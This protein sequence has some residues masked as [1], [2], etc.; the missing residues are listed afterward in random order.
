[1]VTATSIKLTWLAIPEHKEFRG[2]S[3][4]VETDPTG[5]RTKRSFVQGNAGCVP[6]TAA[7]TQGHAAIVAD[8]CFQQLLRQELLKGREY[9]VEQQT[10]GGL[11][12]ATTGTSYEVG[13]VD[14]T[15]A[16]LSGLWRAFSYTS[17][18][19]ETAWEGGSTPSTKRTEYFYN[20]GCSWGGSLEAYGRLNCVKEFERG[21]PFRGM[22]WRVISEGPV[23]QPNRR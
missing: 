16:P 10:S 9:A 21:Y 19:D 8:S 20:F 13:P 22:D 6:G 1:M 4:R 14:Y 5:A 18:V 7:R 23:E 15:W 11:I 17:A 12:L 2:H 3:W